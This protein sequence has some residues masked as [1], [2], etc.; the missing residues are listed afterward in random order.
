M[1]SVDEFSGFDAHEV[2]DY[3]LDD[4]P[5][6]IEEDIVPVEGQR[7]SGSTVSGDAEA[8]GPLFPLPPPPSVGVPVRPGRRPASSFLADYLAKHFVPEMMSKQQ[9]GERV[10][11]TPLP[12]HPLCNAP[13]IDADIAPGSTIARRCPRPLL[14]RT[15]KMDRQLREISE[16]NLS[17]LGPLLLLVEHLE[18]GEENL[19]ADEVL[20]LVSRAV[21]LVIRGSR[22]C[23]VMRRRS[24]LS[25]LRLSN[26]SADRKCYTSFPLPES[27]SFVFGP[28][29]D[30]LISDLDKVA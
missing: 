15:I 6:Q 27:E 3:D 4:D 18:L 23:T 5:L 14:D 16:V 30:E 21:D 25:A 24:L 22:L 12:D 29:L 26:A 7:G 8:P 20:G 28:L 17:A 9:Y 2:L 10:A 11:E 19:S 13:I 1:S